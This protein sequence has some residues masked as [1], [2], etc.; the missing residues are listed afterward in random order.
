M[1]ALTTKGR[2]TIWGLGLAKYLQSIRK[3]KG[4]HIADAFRTAGFLAF[5]TGLVAPQLYYRLIGTYVAPIAGGFVVGVGVGVAST[6]FLIHEA[7][8]VGLVEEGTMINYLEVHTNPEQAWEEI[9]SPTAIK[10]NFLTIWNH[11][12]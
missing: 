2:W 1:V 11:Y 5:T 8:Q 4:D 12:F 6:A 7:E 9:Y 3:K 10:D